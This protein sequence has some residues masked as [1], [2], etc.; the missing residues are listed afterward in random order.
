MHRD[1]VGFVTVIEM[2]VPIEYVIFFLVTAQKNRFW[3][4]GF[5]QIRNF[6]LQQSN[7][8]CII[9]LY[10]YFFVFGVN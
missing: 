2:S 1:K 7:R 10:F 5:V 9:F 3:D 8:Y 4:M 6:Y